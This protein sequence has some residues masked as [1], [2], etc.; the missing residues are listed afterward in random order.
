[1]DPNIDNNGDK[2]V[3]QKIMAKGGY[4]M[5]SSQVSFGKG[6][7][8]DE[9]AFRK[10]MGLNTRMS[11]KE[12]AVRDARQSNLGPGL[13]EKVVKH[14]DIDYIVTSQSLEMSIIT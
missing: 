9:N 11:N 2:A 1:M 8:Q 7:P 5:A 4:Y 12:V 3:G 13:I 14:D 10:S 6:D